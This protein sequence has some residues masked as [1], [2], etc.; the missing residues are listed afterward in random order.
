MFNGVFA[1]KDVGEKDQEYL[2]VDSYQKES[3]INFIMETVLVSVIPD[4]QTVLVN[5]GL[6]EKRFSDQ[7]PYQWTDGHIP[8]DQIFLHSQAG[9]PGINSMIH[10]TWGH[11]VGGHHAGSWDK[12]GRAIIFPAKSVFG[13]LYRFSPL[14]TMVIGRVPV[15][16]CH[17]VVIDSYNGPVS[18][19]DPLMHVHRSARSTIREAVDDYCRTM[20]PDYWRYLPVDK[21]AEVRENMYLFT[22]LDSYFDRYTNV[23][24][25]MVNGTVLSMIT[26]ICFTVTYFPWKLPSL[27]QSYLERYGDVD[28]G[29]FTESQ[30]V[31]LLKEVNRQQRRLILPLV[32]DRKAVVVSV[33]RP[34]WAE[35]GV[36][37]KGLQEDDI[38][39]LLNTMN[40]GGL[41]MFSPSNVGGAS[42]NEIQYIQKAFIEKQ[43]MVPYL[44]SSAD[45]AVMKIG[46]L[47]NNSD[48]A[49]CLK[50]FYMDYAQ[51]IA[52]HPELFSPYHDGVPLHR[53]NVFP[54]GIG[55]MDA[56]QLFFTFN[57]DDLGP[58]TFREYM[59]N[60]D[61][62]HG[63]LN[64]SDQIHM[65]D[66][67]RKE[68]EPSFLPLALYHFNLKRRLRNRFLPLDDQVRRNLEQAFDYIKV[69]YCLLVFNGLDK[70]PLKKAMDDQRIHDLCNELLYFYSS[71]PLADINK[72][73]SV[74]DQLRNMIK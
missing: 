59:A 31:Q 38:W 3:M 2:R 72:M 42:G 48:Q 19:G 44:T 63:V 34:F 11:V 47:D 73:D 55:P 29:K 57:Q 36:K 67:H 6:V 20:F 21:P 65:L 26:S 53:H 50:H 62:T 49:F 43:P 69:W 10:C 14:D 39:A 45:S 23:N 70:V 71:R 32:T 18:K 17:M 51:L 5:G 16:D 30:I 37:V 66:I 4:G 61:Y 56:H 8:M 54:Y 68:S 41:L 52:Q 74:K 15:G 1:P 58:Q 28:A 13:Q 22:D 24:R 33:D 12:Y 46:S 7:Q 27:A 64:K 25:G 9:A 35:H 40:V 60:F